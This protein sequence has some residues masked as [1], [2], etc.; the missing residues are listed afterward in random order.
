MP[1]VAEAIATVPAIMATAVMIISVAAIVAAV[2]VTAMVIILCLGSTAHSDGRQGKPGGSK[3][4]DDTHTQLLR[5][6][7]G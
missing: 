5:P 7:I 3:C 6:G 1:M 4:L 2:V